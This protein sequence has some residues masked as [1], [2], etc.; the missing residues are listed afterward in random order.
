MMT[1]LDI[2]HYKCYK[3]TT[4]MFFISFFGSWTICPLKPRDFI[5]GITKPPGMFCVRHRDN[6]P[7]DETSCVHNE[8]RTQETS[9]QSPQGHIHQVN[10]NF[11]NGVTK[12]KRSGKE[13]LGT[14]R[15]TTNILY[16]A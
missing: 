3:N 9:G 12:K 1:K 8:Y 13:N 15:H 4:W 16:T 6:M 5:T 7:R 14:S 11:R 2:I 10:I